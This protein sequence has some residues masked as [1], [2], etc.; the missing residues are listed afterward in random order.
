MFQLFA[1]SA[2]VMGLSYTIAK[3]ALFAPLRNRCGGRETWLGYLV[4]CPYCVSH[5]VAFIVVPLTG[6]YDVRMAARVP[7]VS[8]I[9]DWFL[10]SIL[11]T[12]V[13]AFLRVI[14]FF[15][16]ETQGFVRRRKRVAEKETEMVERAIEERPQPPLPH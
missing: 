2:V 4:S 7:V 6:T 16:D 9:V 14:F 5:W 13:A 15:V 10:S 3:E 1:V 8:P 12:V 11:V